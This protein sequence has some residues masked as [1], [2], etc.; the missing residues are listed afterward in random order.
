LAQETAIGN[1]TAGLA[2]LRTIKPAQGQAST[3]P[4]HS[5]EL[6]FGFVLDGRATLA[7]DEHEHELAPGDAFAIP[8]QQPW[9]LGRPSGDFRLLHVTTSAL[10]EASPAR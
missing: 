8:P 9:S 5:G 1:A 10:D 7:A 4:P 6:V 2:E 3:F